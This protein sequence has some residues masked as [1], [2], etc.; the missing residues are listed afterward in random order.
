V[1]GRA[2]QANEAGSVHRREVAAWLAAHGLASRGL[3][4]A[5]HAADGPFPMRLDFETDQPTD[6]I[7]CLLSDGSCMYVSAKRTCGN[8]QHFRNTVE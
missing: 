3:S 2:G 7:N 8:D 6:D 4:S 1:P 5:G